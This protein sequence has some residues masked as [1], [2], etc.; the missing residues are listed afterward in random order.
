MKRYA[1]HAKS[2]VLFILLQVDKIFK[3]IQELGENKGIVPRIRFMAKDLAELRQNKWLPRVLTKK[4]D[5]APTPAPQITVTPSPEKS[6]PTNNHKDSSRANGKPTELS[7]EDA[8]LFAA[9][10]NFVQKLKVQRR[11]SLFKMDL[12]FN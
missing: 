7:I 4:T 3:S 2:D 1:F 8:E 6:V 10:E 9:M 11:N 12:T 5:D